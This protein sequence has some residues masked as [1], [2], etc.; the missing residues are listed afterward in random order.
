MG[1]ENMNTRTEGRGNLYSESIQTLSSFI[2][3]EDD[4][5]QSFGCV[6][7]FSLWVQNVFEATGYAVSKWFSIEH[8]THGISFVACM[9]MFIYLIAL[10]YK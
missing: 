3:L 9:F 6:S 5:N 8:M 4:V 10:S 7:M 2:F 1:F